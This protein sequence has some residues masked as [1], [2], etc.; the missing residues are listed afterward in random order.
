M[1]GLSGLQTLTLIKETNPLLPVVMITK[2]E[3]ENIMD[4]A[5]G[6]KIDD[7]LIKP[8]NPNQILLSI[9]KNVHN[10]VLVN[11]KTTTDYQQAFGKI[12]QQIG[13]ARTFNEWV[14][15]YKKL[16]QWSLQISESS[17]SNI[18]QV[19]E[20]Q[21][22][23]ANN[24]FGKFI[25]NN[26]LKWFS[27]SNEN[28]PLMSHNVLR[29]LVFPTIDAGQNVLL[30]LVDNFRF[31]QWKAIQGLI[32]PYWRLEK[33]VI[34]STILPTS[35]QY[36]RNA[37][38]SGLMPLEI[39][40]MHPNL[41]VF[42]E[43]DTGKN[44]FE[45]ELLKLQLQ[46]LG[47]N[48]RIHYEK[49]STLKSTSSLKSNLKELLK[50]H[51]TVLVYNFIDVISHA[52]TEMEMMR[53]LASDEAAYISLTRSWFK[54]SDLYTLLKEASAAKVKLVITTDHGTIRVKNPVKVVGD[55]ATS[56]NLRYK[57]GKNLNYNPKEVFEIRKPEE[58]HLP[59]PNVSSSYIFALG[60]D[61]FAY[62]NN[63]NYYVKYY[64]DTFQ[65]GGISIEEMMV[66][67]LEFKPV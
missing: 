22:S 64:R 4:Q 12:G 46:R 61:F 11:E 39:Q 15:I 62:P 1:P 67:Y 3:E 36:A 58:A 35:T 25:K 5:V 42:D 51:L 44:L 13:M 38:F 55:K 33:E 21:M 34:Y 32:A 9:K 28:K 24:E 18:G 48:Y 17:D 43:D 31:D 47:K 63:F 29:N 23:E 27:P 60:Y 26:Y 49:T 37:L 66:P 19:F 65:H 14:D 7:Y 10:R 8:V 6:A 20:M 53:Q 41:W 57:L 45:E 2:S 54:H 56:T 52:R 59:K 30:I 16:T 50:N 40:R